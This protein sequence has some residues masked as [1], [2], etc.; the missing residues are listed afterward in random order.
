MPLHPEV[1]QFLETQRSL[2]LKPIEQCT[3]D[4]F[5]KVMRLAIPANGEAEPME[6]VEDREIIGNV[7]PIPLR[8]YRPQA[9]KSAG[10]LVYYHGG[11]WVGGDLD[12]HDS[13]CRAI[14]NTAGCLV[15]AVDYRLAPEHKYPVAADDAH[16]AFTWAYRHAPELDIAPNQIAVGG[17]SA[18]GNLAAVVSLMARDRQEHLPCLQV[19]VYPIV[20]SDF[21][22]NSYQQFAEGCGLTASGMKWFWQ[23][24]LPDESLS[25]EPYVSPLRTENLTGL[26]AALV[27]TAEYDVLRDEGNQYAQ[28]LQSAGIPTEWK[29]YDGMIHGFVGRVNIFEVAREAC[30]QMGDALQRAFAS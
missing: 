29:C 9:R 19:L 22:T 1:I 24:Y 8:I 7:G 30:T 14:A 21:S 10:A 13:L 11:G 12:T 20:D 5:R 25:R 27:I 6:A 15:I 3:P 2:E 18:G 26:P 4:E 28:R 17:D 16:A 23:Q